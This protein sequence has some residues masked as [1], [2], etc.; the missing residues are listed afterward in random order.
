[1]LSET[2]YHISDSNLLR[3]SDLTLNRATDMYQESVKADCQP[4]KFDHD[5]EV[6]QYIRNTLYHKEDK[7]AQYGKKGGG[8]VYCPVHC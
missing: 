5:S 1:M 2:T 4:R 8:V 6:V 7:K 3:E